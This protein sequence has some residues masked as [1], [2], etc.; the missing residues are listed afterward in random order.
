M[1]ELT[2]EEVL[3]QDEGS[4]E[5]RRDYLGKLVRDLWISWAKR[6][7]NPKA[8]WLVPYEELSEADKEADRVIGEGLM[9]HFMTM[10]IDENKK[11]LEQNEGE[12]NG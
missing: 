1:S 3:K 7:P 8:S 11:C 10:S 12:H 6:Q 9:L 5:K 2:Y 4:R